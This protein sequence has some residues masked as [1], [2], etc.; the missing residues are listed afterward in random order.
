[1]TDSAVQGSLVTTTIEQMTSTGRATP[2]LYVNGRCKAG[3]VVGC[4]FWLMLVD[5]KKPDQKGTA[6]VVGFLVFN[7]L[8]Q[9]VAYGTGP[10]VKG[11]IVVTPTSN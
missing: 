7:G 11:D 1:M 2:T 8:G 3:E 4:R 6:D 5:N 9:R 10:V